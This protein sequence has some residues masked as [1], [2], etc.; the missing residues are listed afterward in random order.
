MKKLNVLGLVLVLLLGLS[1]CFRIPPPIPEAGGG[2]GGG[3]SS[4]GLQLTAYELQRIGDKIFTNEAG[5]DIGKLVH[6]NIGEDFASMGIGHFTWYPPGRRQTYG[7]TFPGLVNY[8]HRNGARAPSWL[9]YSAQ[10]GAPWYSRQ[11]LLSVKH[12]PQVKQLE[13]YLYASRGLQAKYILARAQNAVPRLVNATPPY[14]RSRVS[15]NLNALANTRG[16]WYPIVDYVNFK[17]EGLNRNGGYRGQNWGLLQVLEE[18][19]PSPP[20]QR[21]LNEFAE[22]AYR[23]L[24]R[25]VQNSPPSRNEA[26]WLP[27]WRNRVNTYRYP[28]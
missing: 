1:G 15:Q 20:G 4:G 9:L 23:V 14:L 17:G 2:S 22:A 19:N 21:A 24:Y 5:G 11:E 26:R 28:L 16:G 12:T 27:G 13:N 6:W 10:R 18:M 25:R 7:S 3:G 8:L